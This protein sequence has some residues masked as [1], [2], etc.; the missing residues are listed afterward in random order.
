MNGMAF[1]NGQIFILGKQEKLV[2]GA[3]HYF[4]VHPEYWEDRL[5]KLKECGCNC[6][7]T[8]V[9]WNLHEK[10]EGDFD[11]SGWLD[12]G[13][14]LDI[15]AK[16][17]LYAIVRPGPYI[18]SEWDMGGLPWWLLKE[19]MGLRS[20]DP[21]FLE[22]CTPYLEKVCEIMRPRLIGKG[23]NIVFVQ[24]ENEYGS[25][26]NDK[27]YLRWLKDFYE[28]HG[29]DCGLIT[30]DGDTEFLLENGTLPDVPASV[31][32][33]WDSK[34]ALGVLKKY[35]GQ[36]PLAVMELWNGKACHWGEPIERRDIE[37]VKTSVENAVELAELTNLYMF[38]GGT[39]F[40]FMNGILNFDDKKG[41]VV[42]MT[43][44][45]VDAPIDEYGRRTEKYYAEQDAIC[46]I[47]KKEIVNTAKDPELFA[48]GAP[49]YQGETPLAA[50]G[51]LLTKTENAT[52]LT[53][54]E[55]NQ[56]Y[57]YIVYETTVFVSEKGGE[58]WIDN[59]YDIAHVYIGGEYQCTL[60]R[61]ITVDA[62]IKI[63]LT[64]Y[65]T[66]QIVVENIGR[67]HNGRYIADRKGLRD[68]LYFY[69]YGYNVISTCFGYK[70]YSLLLEKLP[71]E[72]NKK[73][74]KKAPAF[75]RYTF[76]VRTK[77]DTVLHLSGFTRGVAFINGFNLGRHWT[78]EHSANKLFI[79]APLLKEGENEIVVFDVLATEQEK[80]LQLKD[81]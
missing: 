28:D 64:G 70:M 16:L 79:P 4:R 24:V 34:S 15:A 50:H 71:K 32:Y 11:F 12:F 59:V 27:K 76:D 60:E 22:K 63:P 62:R 14:Y 65:V 9:C 48:Y 55:C 56:G 25:Y 31:N 45:D 8:Y 35:H 73:A 36:F 58:L 66:V 10:T 44:Y 37:E 67:V 38:H 5:L 18:C 80:I 53:M 6:V 49:V 39:T 17:G 78:I 13:K 43:S 51:E 41:N 19:K 52:V 61:G 40:G 33:R 75:Y 72:Y 57:G 77:K 2:S 42:Q 74:E 68:N 81:E 46:T 1:E 21:K 26:G 30:S 7:E 29:I 3:I 54:E 69:D 47:L 23:G 20:S